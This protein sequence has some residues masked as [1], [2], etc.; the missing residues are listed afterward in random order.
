M[1]GTKDG[2]CPDGPPKGR[3]WFKL[4]VRIAIY[5]LDKKYKSRDLTED[6]YRDRA[7]VI[8]IFLFN[9]FLNGHVRI[10]SY[11]TL[12]YPG[13]LGHTTA[14]GGKKSPQLSPKP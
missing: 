8:I 7:H 14:G 10:S 13:S 9:L 3:S 4:T 11:L 12:L 5:A 2:P 6:V 1:I